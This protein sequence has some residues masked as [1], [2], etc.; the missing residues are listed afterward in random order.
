MQVSDE[1]FLI[2]SMVI[3]TY[4]FAEI[5]DFIAMHGDA[6]KD[7]AFEVQDLD[8]V[9]QVTVNPNHLLK[10]CG[11]GSLVDIYECK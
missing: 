3:M 4:R 9:Y 5:G 8:N 2:H 7:L 11:N 10:I 1:F 6:V